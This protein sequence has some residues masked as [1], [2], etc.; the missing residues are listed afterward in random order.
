[1]KKNMNEI[2]QKTLQEIMSSDE[3][4][5]DEIDEDINE[6][7]EEDDKEDSIN[8]ANKDKKKSRYI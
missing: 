5:A 7:L 2:E 6:E 4:Y 3:S 1:M 8:F